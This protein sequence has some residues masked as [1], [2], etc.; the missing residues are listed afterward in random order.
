M[1]LNCSHSLTLN[2]HDLLYVVSWFVVLLRAPLRLWLLL[3]IFLLYL[4]LFYFSILLDYVTNLHVAFID[5]TSVIL[6]WLISI[7]IKHTKQVEIDILS[8]DDRSRRVTVGSNE[9]TAVITSLKPLTSYT[10]SLYVVTVAG[11]STPSN[12]SAMTLS[13]SKFNLLL[14]DYVIID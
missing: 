5:D 11:R 9:T 7:S 8:M 6:H 1:S 4:L 13:T 14:P 3:L 10:F 2:A 12:I